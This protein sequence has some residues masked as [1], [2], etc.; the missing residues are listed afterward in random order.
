MSTIPE[1]PPE[2]LPICALLDAYQW[3]RLID[4]DGS[5]RASEAI[6]LLLSRELRPALRNWYRR[7]GNTMNPYSIEFR[8]QLSIMAGETFG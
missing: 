8:N 4:G 7:P 1:C 6:E 2:Q 5:S 3:F